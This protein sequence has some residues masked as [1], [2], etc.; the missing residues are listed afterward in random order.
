MNCVK[1]GNPAERRHRLCPLC[2]NE[3]TELTRLR[4][5]NAELVAGLKAAFG[6]F[7]EQAT[8]AAVTAEFGVGEW[9][10]FLCPMGQQLQALIAK[11]E[12]E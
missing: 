1:C 5:L 6:V 8:Q 4:A 9:E 12:K 11:C 7:E 2:E 10:A 3:A